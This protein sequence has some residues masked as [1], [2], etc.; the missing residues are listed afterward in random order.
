MVIVI[1]NTALFN[2]QKQKHP[3]SNI[4]FHICKDEVPNFKQ[5]VNTLIDVRN[6]LGFHFVLLKG[7]GFPNGVECWEGTVR[8]KW[9]KTA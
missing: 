8:G 5:I 7:Q 3:H 6:L 2:M 4:F 9:P 1:F